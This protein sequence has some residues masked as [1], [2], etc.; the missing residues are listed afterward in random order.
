MNRERQQDIFPA[1]QIVKQCKVLKEIAYFITTVFSQLAPVKRAYICAG[2]Q[3]L[4]SGWFNN[5]S[6]AVQQCGFP[7]AA[8]SHNAQVFTIQNVKGNSIE[9]FCRDTF[10]GIDLV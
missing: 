8:C 2:K 5:R 1:C 3:D 9:G 4:A 7:G 6:N 10:F